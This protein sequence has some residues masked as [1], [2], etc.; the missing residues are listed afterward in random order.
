MRSAMTMRLAAVLALLLVVFGGAPLQAGP[1]AVP[2]PYATGLGSDAIVARKL[3]VFGDSY[4][5]RN[6]KVFHNWAEQLV[7]DVVNPN[8]GVTLFRTLKDLAVSGATAG[9]YPGSTNN[10]ARQ[11]ASWLRTDPTFGTR[12]LTVV[13]LGYN[14]IR[15]GTDPSGADLA[16]SMTAYRAGL[17]QIVAAGAT[18]KSRRIFL[19]MPHDWG[20]SP[21]YVAN[22]QSVIMRQRTQRWNAFL[23]DLAQQSSYSRLVA[24]DL[25]TALECVFRQPADF[26]FAN[27]TQPRPKSAPASSYLFDLNDDLHFGERGQ[28]LIRQV[29]QY[30]LTRG[31]D[32]SN[33]YK[34]PAAARAR[35]V[36]D[37][38][39]GLVFPVS[40][41]SLP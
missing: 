6:R 11:T 22:G 23:S 14:D 30:Y 20:R 38:R 25:F 29:V 16:G 41:T 34:D 2:N 15:L 12:D 13:Y 40:C 17:Q 7:Y 18:G 9:S 1:F 4:S 37:L 3:T 35:L 8:T 32:W 28:A 33:T 24:V 10:L 39:A 19:V 21:R 27:V 31:W 5:K 26:G 36:A